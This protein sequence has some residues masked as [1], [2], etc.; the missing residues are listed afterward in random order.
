MPSVLIADDEEDL[1]F[2]FNRVLSKLYT[3]YEAD[4][5]LRAIELY[6]KHQPD[7][8]I[9]DTRMPGLDGI[10]ATRRIMHAH[11]D[12]RIIGVTGYAD[13]NAAF[14]EAGALAVIQKPF[15]LAELSEYVAK[16]LQ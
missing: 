2:I 15:S 14:Q 13:K 12:A 16:Y 10:E 4:T 1:R 5:G 7:L 11:P 8:V 3:V 9:M 6:E